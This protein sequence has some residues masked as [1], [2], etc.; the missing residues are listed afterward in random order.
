[1]LKS[2]IIFKHQ[3]T[4]GGFIMSNIYNYSPLWGSWIVGETI[5]LNRFGKTHIARAMQNGKTYYSHIKHITIPLD[6]NND[7]SIE[8]VALKKCMVNSLLEEIK[9][10]DSLKDFPNIHTYDEI[11]VIH[12]N[13]GVCYDIFM[14][15]PPFKDL[16]EVLCEKSLT[17][18]DIIKMAID[19]CGALEITEGKNVV[20]KH[21]SPDSVF[22]NLDDKF[23]IGDFCCGEKLYTFYDKSIKLKALEYASPEEYNDKTINHSS[24][25]YSIGLILYYLFNNCKLPFADKYKAELT[26]KEYEDIIY[27]RL[28]SD[29]LP[30]P[31]NANDKISEIIFKCC[32]VKSENRWL[33]ASDLKN[34]LIEYYNE[35]LEKYKHINDKPESIT[36]ITTSNLPDINID[37]I[38]S[39]IKQDN[40]DVKVIELNIDIKHETVKTV[41]INKNKENI[42]IIQETK[43]IKEN[44]NNENIP[45]AKI[46][47]I[48][49]AKIK[50]NT[51]NLPITNIKDT[52]IIQQSNE[53]N[54]ITSTNKIK[55]ET[56]NIDDNININNPSNIPALD[57]KYSE[58]T[59]VISN[60]SQTQSDKK[61]G[62]TKK[63]AII[64]IF[65][66]IIIVAASI[67]ILYL[68]FPNILKFNSANANNPINTSST[69]NLNNNYSK[70]ISEENSYIASE[71]PITSGDTPSVVIPDLRGKTIEEAN[72]LISEN[73]N[74]NITITFEITYSYNATVEEGLII[75]QSVPENTVFTYNASVQLEV[76]KGL[77]EDMIFAQT[78]QQ[79]LEI[80]SNADSSAILKLYQY[81]NGNWEE[82]FTC[83]GYVGSDGVS[84]NYGEDSKASPKGTFN[85]LFVFGLTKPNT[86]LT[87]YSIT[88]NTVLVTDT[89]SPY[90]NTLQN[91]SV[92]GDSDYENTYKYF[93]SDN[94]FNYCI[95]FDCNGD[96]EHQ[97]SAISGKGSS[98]TICGFN[99]NLD[100]TAGCIDISTTD[101]LLLLSY[102]DSEKKPVV[103]IS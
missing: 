101:M 39:E 28:T 78:H 61:K 31:I 51:S 13:N 11:K 3:C 36:P 15:M 89:S 88:E 45:V 9:T 98:L 53:N 57:I 22:L 80:I 79:K 99:G 56:K 71:I 29:K 6:N 26:S 76:S 37:G 44:N 19:L 68:L 5:R 59:E 2:I 67:I 58:N 52:V 103:I 70:T 60:F 30:K 96:G 62:K 87:F 47:N 8:A 17:E 74:D 54:D 41:S 21:L 77:S 35:L 20:H 83:N 95:F 93:K 100:K 10:S 75:S 85:I 69:E 33:G 49:V 12:G 102:L 90:Y 27:K 50:N 46:K 73:N 14:R 40:Q 72:Q 48:S 66:G 84:E 81:N 38:E 91:K 18:A 97:G 34:T 63:I 25:L 43:S 7:I 94:L 32:D 42:K 86:N 16:N 64:S 24:N 82:I 65:T 55:K 92:I 23:I 4:A 1:M